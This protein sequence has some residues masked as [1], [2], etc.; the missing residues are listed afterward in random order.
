M[1][2]R[3][4]TLAGAVNLGPAGPLQVAVV[5]GGWAGLSAA[6]Q[7]S[8]QGHAVTLFEMAPQWG[9]RARSQRHTALDNG[10]H[11]L[12]GA[13]TQTL[14]L[15]QQVGVQPDQ[16]LM[17][18]RL[19]LQRPDGQGLQLRP[20]PAAS[21]FAAAVMRC[22]AWTWADKA[23]LLLACSRW[24]VA[25]FRCVPDRSVAALCRSLPARVRTLLI[26]PLCVAA[27]NTPAD[28]ASAEVFLRVL[29]DGLFGGSG[30]CDL[31]L[32][33]QPLDAMLPAPATRWLAERGAI[34]LTGRRVMSVKATA[35]RW[36]V[37]GQAF[38]A[39]VLASTAA[40]SARLVRPL[41][42]DWAALADAM[43]YEP[44]VT[45]YVQCPGAHLPLPMLALEEDQRSPAQFV[46]DHGAVG[47]M[48]GRFAFVVSGASAWVERGLD[49]L[50]RAVLDQARRSLPLPQWPADR[51]RVEHTVAERRATFRCTPALVR[52]HRLIAP[53]LAVAGDYV[54]GPYP[55]TLE[56]AVRSG[57]LALAAAMQH[58]RR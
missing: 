52:P 47:G 17:R 13:Y 9:G 28:E 3:L 58:L 21:A 6:V 15:M 11:L 35:D 24:A 38:D 23:R 54:E 1:D 55:A 12:I 51:A 14:A 43:Q 34:L 26:E 4:H 27:L 36:L 5:G 56:G 46:F 49:E 2:C 10:Q 20:G 32:P 8:A 7:A 53:G 31:L 42:A 57:P 18:H 37:D 48:A 22:S 30:A 50:T 41:A 19:V 29:H 25:G 33:R 45:V 39:V 40:E 44:I 16:V